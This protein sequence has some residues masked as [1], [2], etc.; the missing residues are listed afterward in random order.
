MVTRHSNAG[1]LLSLFT[2][3]WHRWYVPEIFNRWVVSVS[4]KIEKGA[5][6]VKSGSAPSTYLNL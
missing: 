5:I 6:A 4:Q 3:Q 2:Y 1:N